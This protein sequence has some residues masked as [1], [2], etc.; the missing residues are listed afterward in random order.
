MMSNS[1]VELR[2]LQQVKD[3]YTISVPHKY[4][5]KL[6]L[7]KHSLVKFELNNDSIIMKGVNLS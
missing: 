7:H 4:V 2:R 3:S 6:Q 1:E 5:D